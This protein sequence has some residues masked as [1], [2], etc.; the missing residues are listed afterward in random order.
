MSE[1]VTSTGSEEPVAAVETASVETSAT[2]FN[3]KDHLSADL[4]D[5]AALADI[6]DL[7]SLAKS[8]MSAQ[9]MIGGSVRIP[10]ED[11]SDEQRAEFY[12]K[13]KTVPG[14]VKLPNPEN[15]EEVAAFYQSLGAPETA[16]EYSIDMPEGFDIAGYEHLISAAKQAGLTNDQLKILANAEIAK[17]T[18]SIQAMEAAKVEGSKLLDQAFGAD[19][20]AR[21]AGA[22]AAARVYGEK[23][24]DAVNELINGPAGNNPALVM[25]L[26][27]LGKSMSEQGHAGMKSTVKYGTT[28]DEAQ[29]KIEEI[30]N[31]PT[32]PY[33]DQA[34]PGHKEAVDRMQKLY[35]L[36]YPG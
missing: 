6:K 35:A 25:M 19:K 24:P 5:S 31:N 17:N 28:P 1:E 27:D 7:N 23:Y 13:L 29:M 15:A 3:F 8:Y 36:A 34:N 21:L 4:R 26:A 33:Y 12:E 32:H 20:E 2:E 16:E 22:K 9:T 18:D 30:R 11:A 14:V 10:G